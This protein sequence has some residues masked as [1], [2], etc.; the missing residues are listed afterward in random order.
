MNNLKYSAAPPRGVLPS[1]TA[2]RLSGVGMGLPGRA[3]AQAASAEPVPVTSEPAP[4]AVPDAPS[5]SPAPA[6]TP[7]APAVAPPP[8]PAASASA[9]EKPSAPSVE[10]KA[11]KGLTVTAADGKFAVTLRPRIQLR[12][13]LQHDDS[14]TTNEAQVRTLRLNISGHVLVPE[15][16]Y[17]IQLAFGGNDFDKDSSSP[18]FDAFVEYTKLRDLNVR[19]GQYF[20]PF[21]RARTIREFALQFVDRQI[22]IRELTL[23]RDFGLM[24]SSSDLFGSDGVL[25]YNLFVGSGDGKNRFADSKNPY[26]PQTLGVLTVG[27]VVVRPMGPF[28]D[29]QEGDLTRS[30]NPHLAVG[31]AGGYNVHSDRKRSTSGD[32]YTLGTFDYAHAEADLVFKWHGFSL[33][34]EAVLRK[35]DKK[36]NTGVDAAGAAL[37]EYSQ[38]GW[39][40]IV[41]GGQMLT[42]KLEL[43]ARWDDLRAMK[44]TDPAFKKLVDA[45]GHQVGGGLNYYLNGHAFKLQSDYFFIYGQETA[46]ARHVFRVQLDASF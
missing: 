44:G 35:A 40:Y 36:K 30:A 12:N 10:L 37:T 33:L 5:A 16:K 22:V 8:P 18:V 13:T 11:G 24:F 2:V 4:A 46:D 3:W 9:T 43:T 29:D 7:A 42:S 25:A 26:G 31:A 21:D 6:A 27:R 17:L 19:F 14:D 1:L 39:G 15:L 20:V 45:Q 41:Q 32:T 38:E 23:D 28:D 34:G